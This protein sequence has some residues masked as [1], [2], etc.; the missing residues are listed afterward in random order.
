MHFLYG[1][2]CIFVDGP[3]HDEPRQRTRDA[4]LD[5]RLEDL[6][7]IPIR[8]RYDADWTAIFRRY[9]SVFGPVPEAGS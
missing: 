1:S 9:P 5:E 3:H 4:D 8:V 2:A 7:R 6:G